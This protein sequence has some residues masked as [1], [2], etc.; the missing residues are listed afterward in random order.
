M[1]RVHQLRPLRSLPQHL[2]VRCLKRLLPWSK[3]LQLLR[4]RRLLVCAQSLSTGGDAGHERWMTRRWKE[5]E[6]AQAL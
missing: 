4:R 3:N 2:L 1:N 5:S 6:A